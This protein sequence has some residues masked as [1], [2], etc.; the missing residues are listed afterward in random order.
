MEPYLLKETEN[1]L[2]FYKPPFYIMD[3]STNY[4]K[5]SKKELN[6]LKKKNNKPFLLFIEKFLY[7][8]Y[9]TIT[10]ND[11]FNCCQRLDIQTSGI[12]MVSKYNK[13]FPLCRKIINNKNETIKLYVCL[14]NG[15]F[16]NKKGYI[17]NKI[18]CDKKPTYCKTYNRNMSNKGSL[19]SSYYYVL[20][21]YKLNDKFYS[22]VNVRIFTG[23]T[24]Q[25][26]V[27]MNSMN[28]PLVS[29]DRYYISKQLHKDNLELCNRMFLHNYNLVININDKFENII[30]KIP[31]DL[32]NCLQKLESIKSYKY[33]N[34]YHIKNPN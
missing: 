31:P 29:D 30:C 19:S 12:V 27:H 13:Y 7:D 11:S 8:K 17:I 1:F 5:M 18:D 9:K 23:R 16:Y 33:N 6:N 2:F 34:L 3:T 25:I 10:D 24:H 20:K 26:R 32:N 22:L 21:E 14:V 28:C 15:L 4:K